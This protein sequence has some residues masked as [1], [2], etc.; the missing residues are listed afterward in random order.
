MQTICLANHRLE[1]PELLAGSSPSLCRV[2]V[3]CAWAPHCPLRH[4][5]V[6][7]WQL[8]EGRCRGGSSLGHKL[9]CCGAG[10]LPEKGK[11]SKSG[12][13]RVQKVF[14]TLWAQGGKVSQESKN[15]T[16]TLFCTG[17]THFA[18]VQEASCSQ[19]PRDLCTLS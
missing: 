7:A 8:A 11:V 12:S 5:R 1:I 15:S 14:L 9:G 13:G 18:P 2:C 10:K 19:G 16:Q 3:L 17:A 4:V 6:L